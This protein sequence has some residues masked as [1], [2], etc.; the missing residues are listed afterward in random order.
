MVVV[1]GLMRSSSIPPGGAV[2]VVCVVLGPGYWCVVGECWWCCV[3][4][5]GRDPL[6]ELGLSSERYEVGVVS[7]CALGW[8]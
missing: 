4:L 1:G 6:V 2:L 7:G 8:L 3:V 5:G